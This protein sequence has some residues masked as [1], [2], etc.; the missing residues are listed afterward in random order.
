VG[1]LTELNGITRPK[2][3][4]GDRADFEETAR[5]YDEI[6]NQSLRAGLV[7]PL[8]VFDRSHDFLYWSNVK[9]FYYERRGILLS[10]HATVGTTVFPVS[11]QA[12]LEAVDNCDIAVL[13]DPSS[14]EEPGYVSPYNRSMRAHY[15][16][17]HAEAERKLI[18][19]GQF[20]PFSQKLTLYIRLS[21]ASPK[22]KR[23]QQQD[24]PEPSH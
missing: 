16:A 10:P 8:I 13:T 19:V 11:A 17:L 18:P 6:G 5:L 4:P 20:H 12:A 7:E 15:D 1:S 22:N 24:R 23:N 3:P 9:P 2:L 21:P 14:P